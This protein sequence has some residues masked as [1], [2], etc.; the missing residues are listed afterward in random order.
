MTVP[1]PTGIDFWSVRLHARRSRLAEGGRLDALCR[2]RSLAELA[3]A[4]YPGAAS[5]SAVDLQRRMV[6]AT[7]DELM[8]L[9]AH[10]EGAGARLLEW[11]CVRHQVENLKVLARAF[12]TRT[13]MEDVRDYLVPLPAALAAD[14]RALVTA[15]SPEA[16]ADLL[17][18]EPLR[19]AVAQALDLYRAQPRPFFLEVALDRGYFVELLVRIDALGGEDR[20][21]IGPLA[22]QEADAYHVSLAARGRFHYGLAPDRIAPLHVAGTAIRRDR[23]AAMLSAADPAD[24]AAQAVGA[25]IDFVPQTARGHGVAAGSVDPI[26]LESLALNRHL[27]IANALFRRSHVGLGAIVAF[28][29]IR[30][31]ELANLITLSEGI[32]AGLGPEAIRRRLVPRTGLEAAR[33]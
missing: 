1:I 31:V 22:R 33:V 12:A 27:R 26:V 8:A 3:N 29:A 13:L 15:E 9:T 21:M 28:A 32:R 11:L 7:L 4:L 20:E 23:F 10:L 30:R 2:L 18:Q 16:F 14:G 5:M 17:P 25:A 19:R 24:L 6:A